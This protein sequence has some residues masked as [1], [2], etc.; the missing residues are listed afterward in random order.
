MPTGAGLRRA[1][2][3]TQGEVLPIYDDNTNLLEGYP[4]CEN[5]VERSLSF[6]TMKRFTDTKVKGSFRKFDNR[7]KG[8]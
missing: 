2:N 4:R 6:P 7:L 8:E 1:V 5:W 3:A